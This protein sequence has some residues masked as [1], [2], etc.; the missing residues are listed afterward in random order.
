MGSGPQALARFED[1]APLILAQS[2]G[3]GSIVIWNISAD[4]EWTDWQ[5]SGALFAPTIIR[6]A[7]WNFERGILSGEDGSNESQV[8]AKGTITAQPNLILSTSDQEIRVRVGEHEGTLS[9]SG[10]WTPD[11]EV[12]FKP[13]LEEIVL[14]DGARIGYAV[15]NLD[16][17]ESLCEYT[18]GIAIQRQ[19]ESQ[20]RALSGAEQSVSALKAER[21]ESALWKWL[22]ILALFG[23]NFE[24]IFANRT[25]PLRNAA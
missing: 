19:L 11:S 2:H 17:E 4:R 13:G 7:Q 8:L 9:A 20:R 16:P 5:T 24:I 6:M 21:Q 18:S 10:L 25:S 22:L 1:G 23:W 15:W 3:K 12:E 14:V